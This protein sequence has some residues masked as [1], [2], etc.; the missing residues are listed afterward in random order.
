MVTFA[1]CGNVKRLIE[2]DQNLT[3]KVYPMTSRRGA[4]QNKVGNLFIYSLKVDLCRSRISRWG[5]PTLVFGEGGSRG[6][7]GHQAPMQVL[8]GEM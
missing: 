4:H 8:F 5:A 3:V 6:W 2:V 1:D 7:G